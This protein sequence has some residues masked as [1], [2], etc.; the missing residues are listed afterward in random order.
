MVSTNNYIKPNKE[1]LA[2]WVEKA[3]NQ[4]FIDKNILSRFKVTR[5]WP[6]NPT[7][8]HENPSL[9]NLYTTD[10]TIAN[11]KQEE[12]GD[13]TSNEENEMDEEENNKM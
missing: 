1:T 7:T 4:S 6:V 9:N 12:N 10:N 8:M 3:L 11:N 2:N 13:F 5:I